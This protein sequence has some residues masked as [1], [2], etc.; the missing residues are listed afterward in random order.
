MKTTTDIELLEDLWESYK[1]MIIDD[2]KRAKR[3]QD[4]I[5]PTYRGIA[6]WLGL[7]YQ[8]LMLY[9]RRPDLN[10]SEKLIFDDMA[11]FLEQYV[12]SHPSD[13]RSIFLAKSTLGYMEAFQAKQ[14]E[15]QEKALEQ[16]NGKSEGVNINI[17]G[18]L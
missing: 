1:A 18:K 14:L 8:S 10:E 13:I 2:H 6:Q 11:L 9:K 7:S 17:G 3:Q 12:L 4:K 15:L 5:V 16:S